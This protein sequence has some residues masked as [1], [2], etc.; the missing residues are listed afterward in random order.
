MN[1]NAFVRGAVALGA[2]VALAVVGGTAFAFGESAGS[3][4]YYEAQTAY[5]IPQLASC[6]VVE[7]HGDWF[8]ANASRVES[9]SALALYAADRG[10]TNG[11]IESYN[12]ALRQK[13]IPSRVCRND[14]EALGVV[15]EA[16][17][18]DS[19][20]IVGRAK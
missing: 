6:N 1:R 14:L 4:R 18:P 7:R 9:T 17:E 3:Q 13:G 15:L 5:N 11:V 16:D 20:A 10:C 2:A 8:V 12:E 19:C